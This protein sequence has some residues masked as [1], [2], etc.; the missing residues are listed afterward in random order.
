MSSVAVAGVDAVANV[1]VSVPVFRFKISDDVVDA[2]VAFAKIHCYDD[3]HAYKDAWKEWCEDNR[4]MLDVEVKR[5]ENIGY[6]GNAYDKF[7][8]S[9]R[10]YFR[11][12]KNKNSNANANGVANANANGVGNEVENGVGNGVGDAV[13]DAAGVDN[14]NAAVVGARTTERKKYVGLSRETLRVMDDY[15]LSYI[16]RGD[17]RDGAG[18][19]VAPAAAFDDFCTKNKSVLV[20]EINALINGMSDKEINEKLKKTFK[21]RYF[22]KVRKQTQSQSQ[23]RDV[24]V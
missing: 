9:G 20:A 2:I 11:N 21:N 6:T 16:I 3:R 15:L 10:Y 8:K 19:K 18:T 17:D 14:A 5:L 12:K 7:F 24:P 23:T 13:D 22:Q 4:E 1:P